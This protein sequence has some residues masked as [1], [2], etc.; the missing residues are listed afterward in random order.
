MCKSLVSLCT[1]LALLAGA[2]LVGCESQNPKNAEGPVEMSEAPP[3]A[4]PSGHHEHPSEGPHHGALIELGNEEYHAELLHDE[5]EG[6]VT[7]YILDGS[8]NN[9]VPIE[10][11]EVT[12]NLKHDGRGEQFK[13]AAA[14][15]EDDPEGKSSRF[16][17]NDAE[18][19]EDLHAEDAE[20]RLVVRIGE[21]SYSGEVGHEHAHDH[22]HD[23]TH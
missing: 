22:D 13:L 1:G 7:V 4:P 14:P 3:A 12:I 2:G 10:A 20:A 21:K 17:S 6:T 8:A 18:L 5:D 11:Q 9:A 15:M 23:H 19:G 16:V